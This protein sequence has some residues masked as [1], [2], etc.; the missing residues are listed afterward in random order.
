M[1]TRVDRVNENAEMLAPEEQEY[2][3]KHMM[4][5]K[6]ASEEVAMQAKRNL[7]RLNEI[8]EHEE[9]LMRIYEETNCMI[10]EIE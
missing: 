9:L 8:M 3:E 2:Y 10:K 5:T 1:K 6:D 7:E 4:R